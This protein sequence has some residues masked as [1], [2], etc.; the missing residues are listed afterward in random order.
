MLKKIRNRSL[1]TNQYKDISITGKNNSNSV[2]INR[3]DDS[4]TKNTKLLINNNEN[5]ENLNLNRNK[6]I[7]I[8]A[9]RG[10]H[11]KINEDFTQSKHK[12]DVKKM[13]LT[14]EKGIKHGFSLFKEEN[15]SIFKHESFKPIIEL[16][17]INLK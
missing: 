4:P 2:R 15:Y 11:P 6:N 17:S 1:I 10:K 7:P 3:K 14:D 16:V 5:K 13:F 8:K 12:I 9:L